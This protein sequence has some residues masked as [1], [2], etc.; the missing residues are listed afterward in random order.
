MNV[1]ADVLTTR[2]FS[3]LFLSNGT[4]AVIVT[5][6]PYNEFNKNEDG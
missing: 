3:T 4:A 1:G 2:D 5:H 6:V